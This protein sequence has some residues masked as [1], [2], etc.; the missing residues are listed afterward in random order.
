MLA[1]VHL[2][3]FHH[4]D[5]GALEEYNQFRQFVQ[6]SK[7]AQAAVS[8]HTVRSFFDEFT[9]WSD[10]LKRLAM[11]L[12]ISQGRVDKV[13]LVTNLCTTEGENLM[14][15]VTSLSAP[16]SVVNAVHRPICIAF[17]DG[18]SCFGLHAANDLGAIG[19][20]TTAQ[21][22]VDVLT[23]YLEAM[24]KRPEPVANQAAEDRVEVP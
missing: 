21:K 3:W 22:L 9:D 20:C 8:P 14:R 15:G 24:T 2:V 1:T 10:A 5:G 17:D 12:R 23:D 4:D 7:L 11:L 19:Y 16:V 6:Q 13:I 18:A